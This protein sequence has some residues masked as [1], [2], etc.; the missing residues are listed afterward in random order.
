[1]PATN[2]TMNCA[3]ATI[4]A[5]GIAQNIVDQR[6]EQAALAQ[7]KTV[8]QKQPVDMTAFQA[9]KSNLLVFVNDGITIRQ[10]NQAIA[11]VGNPATAG[12]QTV[13]FDHLIDYLPAKYE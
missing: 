13:C 3:A 5:I 6:N 11:P 10:S 1:M 9:A 8:L 12:L 7:V 2:T 4:L